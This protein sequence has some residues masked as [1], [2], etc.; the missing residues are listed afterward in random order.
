MS[1]RGLRCLAPAPSLAR[2]R[3]RQLLHDATSWSDVLTTRKSPTLA[4]LATAPG[5][6]AWKDTD[7]SRGCNFWARD[8]HS[9]NGRWH[10]YCVGGACV[11]NHIGTQR[12]HALESVGSDP[13]GPYTY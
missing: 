6:Q 3:Q 10:L 8:L 2:V 9:F 5:V 13:M 7:T 4:G 11:S 12:T 1:G